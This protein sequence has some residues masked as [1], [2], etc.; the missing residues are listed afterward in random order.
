MSHQHSYLLLLLT[1]I[2]FLLPPTSVD[3]SMSAWTPIVED[4]NNYSTALSRLVQNSLNAL[5]SQRASSKLTKEW[6]ESTKKSILKHDTE[7]KDE[8]VS[9]TQTLDPNWIWILKVCVF[10]LLYSK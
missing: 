6:H 8:F 10:L 7:H 5:Q 4:I 2:S 9:G 3:N 1:T